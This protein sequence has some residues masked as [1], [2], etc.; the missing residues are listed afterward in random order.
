MLNK[1]AISSITVANGI[2]AILAYSI[3]MSGIDTRNP[4][5]WGR[6]SRYLCCGEVISTD[7]RDFQ[8]AIIKDEKYG[9]MDSSMRQSLL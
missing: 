5:S 6:V 8:R 2:V 7:S 3:L 4:L 9:A 1:A